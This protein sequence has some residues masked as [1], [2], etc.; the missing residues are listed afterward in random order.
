MTR[1]LKMVFQLPGSKTMTWTLI[2]PVTGLTKTRVE[3]G[4]NDML[5]E[6]MIEVNG[7]EP[8]SIKELYIYETNKVDL[9]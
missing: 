7:V 5:A 4:L 2:D 1:V 3:T 9:E 8:E 6:S